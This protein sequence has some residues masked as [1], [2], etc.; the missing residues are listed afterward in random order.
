[1][2]LITFHKI[3][4]SKNSTT[5]IIIKNIQTQIQLCKCHSVSYTDFCNL[6]QEKRHIFVM[7]DRSVQVAVRCIQP[8]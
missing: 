8:E 6:L 5:K 7:E 2:Q 3:I 4:F 1:M